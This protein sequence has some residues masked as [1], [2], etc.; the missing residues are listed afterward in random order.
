M[1][2]YARTTK[3]IE[4]LP[5]RLRSYYE[6]EH[7]CSACDTEAE[8]IWQEIQNYLDSQFVDSATEESLTRWELLAGLPVGHGLSVT[9]RRRRLHGKIA[10]SDKISLAYVELR[11]RQMLGDSG[12]VS[13]GIDLPSRTITAVINLTVPDAQGETTRLLRRLIPAHLALSVIVNGRARHSGLH[14][15][16]HTSLGEHTHTEIINLNV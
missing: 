6:Y 14:S 2:D 16:T 12:L 9:D 8:R 10:Q 3:L 4:Y 7:L 15:L 1:S 11:L 13:L 5:A